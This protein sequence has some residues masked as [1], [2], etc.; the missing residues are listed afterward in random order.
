M[1]HSVMDDR[2]RRNRYAMLGGIVVGLVA[3]L[4]VIVPNFVYVFTPHFHGSV[5][6]EAPEVKDFQLT[7]AD[8]G[9]FRLSGYRG[10]LIVLYFGYTSCPD[11]CPATLYNLS[12]MMQQLGDRASQVTVLFVTVDPKTDTPEKLKS[13]LDAFSP[14]FIG[15]TGTQE[16]LQQVYDQFEVKIYDA[17]K[18]EAV[19]SKGLGHDTS[20]YLIDKRGRLRVQLHQGEGVQGILNDVEALLNEL[21]F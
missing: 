9:E 16:Q 12:R 21:T 20:L 3:L 11:E 10:Q 13:Y 8:G 14:N 15:L 19:A 5:F 2:Q 6:W 4:L 1:T 18:G 17:S 7:R